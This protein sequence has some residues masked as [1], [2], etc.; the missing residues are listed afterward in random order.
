MRTHYTVTQNNSLLPQTCSY[1][2]KHMASG[3]IHV[4]TKFLN[5]SIKHTIETSLTHTNTET[6]HIRLTYILLKA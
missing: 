3:H 5:K 1:E 4:L 6:H 2:Q